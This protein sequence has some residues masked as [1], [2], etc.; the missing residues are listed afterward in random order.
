[1][2]GDAVWLIKQ[3]QQM[4]TENDN[5]GEVQLMKLIVVNTI[6]KIDLTT[7]CDKTSKSSLNILGRKRKCACLKKNELIL[8]VATI[9]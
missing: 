1:M 6:E 8:I 9:V 4:T 7:V 3:S 2:G 5:S